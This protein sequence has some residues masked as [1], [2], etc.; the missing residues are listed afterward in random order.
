MFTNPFSLFQQQKWKKISSSTVTYVQ[1]QLSWCHVH[2]SSE[3]NIHQHTVIEVWRKEP[4]APFLVFWGLTATFGSRK[5]RWS[6]RMSYLQHSSLRKFSSGQ[7]LI[8]GV[9]PKIVM[10]NTQKCPFQEA[11]DIRQ[12]WGMKFSVL[13]L[14][15]WCETWRWAEK[16]FF[17]PGIP[18]SQFNIR[19]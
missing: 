18:L 9:Y 16:S 17:I 15:S 4:E 1:P 19:H 13:A 5:R 2:P 6:T 10:D 7:E 14:C 12:L 8:S 3:T 11:R